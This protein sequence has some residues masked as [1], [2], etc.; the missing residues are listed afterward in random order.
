M[1]DILTK[2]IEALIMSDQDILMHEIL[3]EPIS[4]R[5]AVSVEYTHPSNKYWEPMLRNNS[6]VEAN[7]WIAQ[8]AFVVHS[9]LENAICISDNQVEIDNAS[10]LF[11]ILDSFLEDKD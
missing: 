6:T 4:Y 8:L 10:E 5:V 3:I 1:L 11:L 9:L 2:N 7:N